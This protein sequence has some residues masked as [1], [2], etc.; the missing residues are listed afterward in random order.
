[1]DVER[2]MMI[3]KIVGLTKDIMH[4]LTDEEYTISKK[5]TYVT[6]DSHYSQVSERRIRNQSL[7][8]EPPSQ[9]LIPAENHKKVLEVINKIIQLQAIKVPVRCLDVAIYFSVEEWDY[10]E[11]HKDLYKDVIMDDQQTCNYTK[12]GKK[13]FSLIDT[14]PVPNLFMEIICLLTGE[15][16]YTIVKKT[17]HDHVTL[18]QSRVSEGGNRSPSLTTQ[19][20]HH[21]LAAERDTKK[22]ILE[23]TDKITELLTGEVPI[24]CQDVAVYFSIEEWDYVEGHKDHYKDAMMENQFLLTSPDGQHKKT[25]TEEIFISSGAG[26]EDD[27]ITSCSSRDDLINQNLHWRTCH[28][29]TSCDPSTHEIDSPHSYSPDSRE[30]KTFLP[31]DCERVE[32]LFQKSNVWENCSVCEKC[33]PNKYSLNIH[34]RIHTGERPFSCLV[35]GKGF[36]QKWGLTVHERIHTGEKPYSCPDCGK[37]FSDRSYLMSHRRVH[38]GEKPYSCPECGKC[39][40][41]KLGLTAHER[42]HFGEK[43]YRCC[44]CGKIFL[45]KLSFIA[46]KRV[47]AK[48]MSFVCS[49]CGKCFPDDVALGLHKRNHK[50]KLLHICSECGKGFPLKSALL[51][52]SRIHTGERPF[53]CSICGKSFSHRSALYVHKKLHTGEKRYSCPECGKS[54]NQRLNL[55]V[56][57]RV[58]TGEKPFFCSLCGKS[59]SQKSILIRHE[60]IHTGEKHYACS[61]CGKSFPYKS[62]VARHERIHTGEKPFSC[63]ECGK[64]FSRQS[65]LLKHERIH[66][67]EKPFSCSECGKGFSQKSAVVIHERIHTGEKP[68]SCTECGKRFSQQSSLIKHER[69]HTGERPFTCSECGKRF[70]QK[71][72]LIV[73]NKVHMEDSQSYATKKELP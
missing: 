3:E 73:H 66:T 37:Q 71:A 47:H 56:H 32:N 7:T 2:K 13:K 60:T 24:R 5:T 57:E 63:S 41:H 6:L 52:H 39:F 46:H 26:I 34:E 30:G 35:C 58:H 50:K 14:L 33:F 18:G 1:M 59:F 51:V 62:A 16:E 20:P 29:D 70:S 72:H 64:S 15:E 23:V 12:M 21:Y 48:G 43:P 19:P 8:N 31:A 53:I 45:Q 65:S 9:C 44:E 28:E 10:V 38:T 55:V 49:E 27:D 4:L 11:E 42:V 61:K 25:N 17:S 22:K 40:A 54:F 36:V 69:V 67:G 68:Y